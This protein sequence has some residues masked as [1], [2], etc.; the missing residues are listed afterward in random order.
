MAAMM[1]ALNAYEN[2]ARS[3]SDFVHKKESGTSMIDGLVSAVIPRTIPSGANIAD[4]PASKLKESR[5][6]LTGCSNAPDVSTQ[7]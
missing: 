6:A 2:D 5:I 4:T 7:S 1:T 3:L